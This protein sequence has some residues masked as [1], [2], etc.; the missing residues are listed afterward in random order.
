MPMIVVTVACA[1]S[2]LPDMSV[3]ICPKQYTFALGNC[4]Y[5]VVKLF[6]ESFSFVAVASRLRGMGSN[7][8]Y[9]F[10]VNVNLEGLKMVT[11][12][13]DGKYLVT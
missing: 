6:A 5:E 1:V 8:S 7:H 13:L 10:I 2:I 3:R 12:S 9:S 4:A 11:G